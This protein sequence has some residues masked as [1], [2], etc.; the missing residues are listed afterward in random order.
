MLARTLVRDDIRERKARYDGARKITT[1][2][3][4]CGTSGDVPFGFVSSAIGAAVDA[5]KL[6]TQKYGLKTHYGRQAIINE[7]GYQSCPLTLRR[8]WFLFWYGLIEW[9]TWGWKVHPLKSWIMPPDMK[10]LNGQP[11][12]YRPPVVDITLVR[13]DIVNHGDM[14]DTIPAPDI[15]PGTVVYSDEAKALIE[16]Y[17]RGC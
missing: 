4:E 9:A 10:W 5:M 17:I 3:D 16:D 15:V 8:R 6:I 11:R 7:L 2:G 1:G 13:E 14:T 12:G